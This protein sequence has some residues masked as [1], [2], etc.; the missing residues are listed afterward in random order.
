MLL[1]HSIIR[2]A[3]A[4]FAAL[5]LSAAPIVAAPVGKDTLVLVEGG[6]PRAAVVVPATADDQT[7][8]AA[9]L[10]IRYVERATGPFP[11]RRGR[12]S[13][14]L[15]ARVF[16]DCAGSTQAK[17]L[18]EGW[19]TTGFDRSVGRRSPS[20][21]TPWGTEFACEFRAVCRRALADARADGED[22]A[23]R[24]RGARD[25]PAEPVFFAASAACAV[26]RR[27]NGHATG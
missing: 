19:M 27:A 24:I 7:K 21:P 5:A 23:R 12:R 14:A 4:L 13:R 9:E 2:I 25:D 10:L 20:G 18:P 16:V 22:A 1:N 3:T 17:L 11:P 6:K 15:P 8:A 26:Q